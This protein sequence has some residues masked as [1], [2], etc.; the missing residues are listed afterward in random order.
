[1]SD[2]VG[3]RERPAALEHCLRSQ[4]KSQTN[5]VSPP[6]SRASLALVAFMSGQKNRTD[7]HATIQH[8]RSENGW[9]HG[10][11]ALKSPIDG[12]TRAA[13]GDET[14]SWILPRTCDHARLGVYILLGRNTK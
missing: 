9:M 11:I 4:Y 5:D 14:N 7:A 8:A 12:D 1:M 2:T 3:G 10:R 13:E 6:L